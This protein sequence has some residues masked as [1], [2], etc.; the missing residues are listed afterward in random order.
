MATFTQ[1]LRVYRVAFAFTDSEANA[2]LQNFQLYSISRNPAS[3]D[4][5]L[6]D[7]ASPTVTAAGAIC[8]LSPQVPYYLPANR[9]LRLTFENRVGVTAPFTY[10]YRVEF[11]YAHSNLAVPPDQL[12]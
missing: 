3:P 1:D 7:I 6:L 4:P 11:Q 2:T 10:N 9:E 12:Y 8:V 5:Q